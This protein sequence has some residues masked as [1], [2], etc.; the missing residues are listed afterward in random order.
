MAVNQNFGDSAP[1]FS[2]T[3]DK[4][5]STVVFISAMCALRYLSASYFFCPVEYICSSNT[6]MTIIFFQ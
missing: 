5:V 1:Q 6:F 4:H 3:S 2:E